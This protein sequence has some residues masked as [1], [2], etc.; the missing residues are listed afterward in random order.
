MADLLAGLEPASEHDWV[1]AA[2]D[3]PSGTKN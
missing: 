3:K 1:R 2:L